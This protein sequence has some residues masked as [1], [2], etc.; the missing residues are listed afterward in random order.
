MLL[1][2][3]F[4]VFDSSSINIIPIFRVFY[5]NQKYLLPISI[6][7]TH[8]DLLKRITMLPKST[9]CLGGFFRD[10]LLIGCV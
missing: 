8:D 2:P 5:I 4:L 1:H 3:I 10:P 6:A 7:P 9:A